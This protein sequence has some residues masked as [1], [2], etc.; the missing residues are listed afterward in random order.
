MLFDVLRKF[1]ENQQL[2]ETKHNSKLRGKRPK[3][4]LKRPP[5]KQRKRPKKLPRKPRKPPKK[6]TPN[7][8]R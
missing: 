6:K 1:R 3:K 4:Q 7:R 8:Y 2:E 5:R